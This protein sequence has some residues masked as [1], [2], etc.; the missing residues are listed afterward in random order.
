MKTKQN[1][2]LFIRFFAF[3]MLLSFIFCITGCMRRPLLLRNRP[4]VPPPTLD[5]D[6]NEIPVNYR[7]EVTAA[8][9]PVVVEVNED[10]TKP[11]VLEI[12]AV[13]ITYTVKKGESFW[14]IARMYGVTKDELAECN[15]L[16]LKTPLKIG[17]IL[18]IPPGG[19]LNY[20]TQHPPV[21]KTKLHA[22][23]K[24][25]PVKKTSPVSP[26]TKNSD[27]TYIVK[28]GDSLW[29]I[30]RRFKITTKALIEANTIDHK[31]PLMPGMK[32]I[33]PGVDTTAVAVSAEKTNAAPKPVNTPKKDKPVEKSNVNPID[34]ILEDAKKA[35]NDKTTS[36]AQD[37]ID[38]LDAAAKVASTPLPDDLYTEEVLP[39]ETLQEIAERHGFTEEDLRKVNPDLPSDGK[40]KPFSSIKIPNKKY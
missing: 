36:N 4:N 23:K 17:T 1:S 39:N 29:K 15:N 24:I 8:V 27:G 40:L 28:S 33:I 12:K 22:V 30:A 11:T 6:S 5:P 26:V 31:K 20:E 3:F 37:V 32:L 25:K 35:A 18:V 9:P 2:A 14:K 13:P 19:V 34:D 38:G 10:I 7:T 21:K 16:S